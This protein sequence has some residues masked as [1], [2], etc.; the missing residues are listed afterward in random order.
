MYAVVAPFGKVRS[1]TVPKKEDKTH[2]C[3]FFV[4][5]DTAAEARALLDARQVT[6]KGQVAVPQPAGD[7][8][9]EAR[10]PAPAAPAAPSL[11]SAPAPGGASMLLAPSQ[12]LAPNFAVGYGGQTMAQRMVAKPGEL[13]MQQKIALARGIAPKAFESRA[14]SRSPPAAPRRRSRRRSSSRTWSAR[15][16]R[17]T[18]S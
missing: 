6:I 7:A 9:E 1:I 17:S 18:R 16:T 12:Q 11:L 5:F 2:R 4:D 3:F 14:A 13:T 10:A 15:R 8:P